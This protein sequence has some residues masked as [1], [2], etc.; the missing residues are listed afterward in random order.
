VVG[1]D[2][3]Y[4]WILSRTPELDQATVDELISEAKTLGFKTDELIYVSQTQN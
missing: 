2:V 4:L 1:P 3:D